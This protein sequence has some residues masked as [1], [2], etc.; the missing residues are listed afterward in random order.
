MAFTTRFGSPVKRCQGVGDDGLV[1]YSG[2]GSHLFCSHVMLPSN[3]NELLLR[4]NSFE[5]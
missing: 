2:D 5:E 3:M 4:E 1:D